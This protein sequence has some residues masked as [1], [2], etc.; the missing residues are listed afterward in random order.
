MVFPISKYFNNN[1]VFEFLRTSE[2]VFKMNDRKEKD[3]DVEF[4]NVQEISIIGILLIYKFMDYSTKYK[5]FSEPQILVDTRNPTFD[6][7]IDKYGFRQLIYA[8]MDKRY[9]QE[10]VFRKIEVKIDEKFIL[11]PQPLIRSTNLSSEMLNKNFLPKIQQY[12]SGSEKT[13]SMIFQC[14]SEI[15]LNFWE[16]SIEDDNSIVVAEGNKDKIEIACSDNGDGIVST[17]RNFNSSYK[18]LSGNIISEL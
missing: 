5:C 6:E 3:V 15:F 2:K 8:F 4:S 13:V 12:Y 10:S 1:Y 17:L 18:H 11:A 7:A 9:N 14:F 16:H